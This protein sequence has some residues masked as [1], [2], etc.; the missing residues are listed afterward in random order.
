[1]HSKTR[2]KYR[3]REFSVPKYKDIRY[4]DDP[5]VKKGKN[6]FWK[7]VISCAIGWLIGAERRLRCVAGYDFRKSG[8]K[9]RS[10]TA[11]FVQIFWVFSF[12][13]AIFVQ[14]FARKILNPVDYIAVFVTLLQELIVRHVVEVDKYV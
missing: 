3:A 1:M 7:S 12:T 6:V 10:I 13:F 8:H 11:I 9:R 5:A 2:K 4:F 14:K